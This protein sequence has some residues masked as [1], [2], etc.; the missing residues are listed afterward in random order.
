M[1][2]LTSEEVLSQS[3]AA[4][5]TWGPRWRE[6]AQ[7][8]GAVYKREGKTHKDLLMRGRGKRCVVVGLGH[9]LEEQIDV[10]KEYQ[11]YVDISCCDKAFHYLMEHGIKP[12]LVFMA[13]AGVSWE[14]YGAPHA[15][16]TKDIA[17]ISNICGNPK[18][19]A[20]WK[21]PRYFFVNKDNLKSEEE[22]AAI[23]GCREAIPAASN[24]G[25]IALVFGVQVLG[26]DRYMMLGFDGGHRI[27]ENYYAFDWAHGKRSFM[28]HVDMISPSGEIVATSN[29][30]VFSARWLAGYVQHVCTPMGTRVFDCSGGILELPKCSLRTQLELAKRAGRRAWSERERMGFVKAYSQDLVLQQK[31]YGKIPEALKDPNME[32]FG[33]TLHGAA[34]EAIAFANV[35]GGV[36]PVEAAPAAGG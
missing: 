26:Y 32:T 33:V 2:L 20:G 12:T 10:L 34:R 1:Q 15:A 7:I 19:P 18:W 25:N 8:N 29:N 21:G 14:K 4:M 23:S 3:K 13:D 11:Q 22:F 28:H 35:M 17:L 27:D 24:V 36:R 6:H 31:D 30:L 16:E 9:S 5:D